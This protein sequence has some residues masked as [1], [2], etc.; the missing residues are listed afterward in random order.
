M[1]HLSLGHLWPVCCVLGW[2]GTLSCAPKSEGLI[3]PKSGGFIALA[4]SHFVDKL[5]VQI[6][7]LLLKVVLFLQI[8]HIIVDFFS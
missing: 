6:K 2:V 4:L 7:T 3:V 5:C 8:I 1:S